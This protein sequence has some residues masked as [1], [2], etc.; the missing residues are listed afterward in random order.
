MKRSRKYHVVFKSQ[1]QYGSAVLTIKHRGK[2][3]SAKNMQDITT[4]FNNLDE[5]TTDVVITNVIK[6]RHD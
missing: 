6:L 5:I 4:W 3:L 2:W 1:D